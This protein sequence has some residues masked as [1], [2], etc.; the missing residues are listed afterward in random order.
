MLPPI[1]P[2]RCKWITCAFGRR[3]KAK[4][5]RWVAEVQRSSAVAWTTE[6]QRGCPQRNNAGQPAPNSRRKWDGGSLAGRQHTE[7]G[8]GGR[9]ACAVPSGTESRE[10]REVV[11]ARV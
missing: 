2:R 5:N 4:S 11:V 3:R 1:F 6:P 10:K 8:S 9:K 7:L